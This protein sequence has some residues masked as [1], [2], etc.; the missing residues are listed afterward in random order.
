MWI[1]VQGPQGQGE[2]SH[3]PVA[4]PGVTWKPVLY[5]NE[6][7][8]FQY[9]FFVPLLYC[10]PDIKISVK[11]KYCWC[12]LLLACI[13]GGLRLWLTAYFHAKQVKLG[14]C[15]NTGFKREVRETF[16]CSL[17]A[18]SVLD[19]SLY[20]SF[21]N[22]SIHSTLL[23]LF[24]FLKTYWLWNEAELPISTKENGFEDFFLLFFFFLTFSTSNYL[25]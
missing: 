6:K 5:K 10:L 23:Y 13:Y 15:Q 20:W 12:F 9:V 3:W 4:V 25:L 1:K 22:L 18:Q 14:G 2:L 16:L 8:C 19:K 21:L 24:Y 7:F 11:N 17:N